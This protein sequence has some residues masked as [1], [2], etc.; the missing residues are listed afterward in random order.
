MEGGGI[1]WEV[2]TDVYMLLYIKQMGDKE[3]LDSTGKLTQ[4]CVVP[5]MGKESEKEWVSV[6]S[7]TDSLCCTSETKTIL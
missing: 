5:Y 4:Y 3:L 6:C 2:G 1:N 7:I